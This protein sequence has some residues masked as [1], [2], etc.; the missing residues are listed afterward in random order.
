MN[1]LK[2]LMKGNVLYRRVVHPT[3]MVNVAYSLLIADG[4]LLSKP[5]EDVVFAPD[6][7]TEE[8]FARQWALF[9]HQPTGM[10]LAKYA[11]QGLIAQAQ[12]LD[13]MVTTKRGGRVIL[14]RA[15][16]VRDFTR[17][18]EGAET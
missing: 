3:K 10:T 1:Y 2:L 4:V 9:T 13:A 8:S 18:P 14:D 16:S 6:S 17:P 5:T 7:L 12:V 11:A 15:I